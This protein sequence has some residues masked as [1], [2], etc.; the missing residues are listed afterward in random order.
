MEDEGST[1]SC[2]IPLKLDS[3]PAEA[4][5]DPKPLTGLSVLVSGSQQI[6]RFVI[7]EW[8]QRWGMTVEQCDLLH[9]QRQV[10]GAAQADRRFDILVVQAGAKGFPEALADFHSY[11][12][13]PAPKLILLASGSVDPATRLAADAVLPNPVRAK[14]LKGA[15][16]QLAPHGTAR[17]SPADTK[18]M[19]GP[20]SPVAGKALKVLVTDDNLINQKLACALLSRLGCDVD[21]ADDGA[22]AV[23]KVSQGQYGLVF[24]DCVMPG[25]DGFDATAAIR[26]LAGKCARVPIVALTASA[27]AEDR[28]HCLAVGMD[29]FLTKPIRSAQLAT[30][31]EKWLSK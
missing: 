1:F 24:M 31:L 11:S 8:C 19:H 6:A 29:D 14:V 4:L 7:A 17:P 12:G 23:S 20:V 27:T 18:V 5:P 21:T 28:D 13:N 26:K 16:C 2:K 22:A 9:L 3:A 15:L 30:C 25:M 10:T